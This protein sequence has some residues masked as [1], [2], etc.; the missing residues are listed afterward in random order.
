MECLAGPS[1]LSE[2]CRIIQD[3][4][5]RVAQGLLM[6]GTLWKVLWTICDRDYKGGQ[7]L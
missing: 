4:A 3:R 5:W 6:A 1:S 7:Y 2:Q